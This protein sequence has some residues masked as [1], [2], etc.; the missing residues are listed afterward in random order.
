LR[1]LL[2]VGATEPHGEVGPLAG[3]QEFESVFR[4]VRDGGQVD[5][6]E[7]GEPALEE[8]IEQYV[9]DGEDRD[10][11]QGCPSRDQARAVRCAWLRSLSGVRLR[12][13]SAG[14]QTSDAIN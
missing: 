3:G 7:G 10:A 9:E 5:G 14:Q 6:A 13:S 4:E 2:I 12:C 8:V 1:Q 11:Q